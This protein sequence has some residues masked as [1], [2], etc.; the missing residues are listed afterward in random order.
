[1]KYKSSFTQPVKLSIFL[2]LLF[3]AVNCLV[4]TNSNGLHDALVFSALM[5]AFTTIFV[6]AMVKGTNI[7]VENNSVTY[8]QMSVLRTTMDIGKINKIQKDLM[9]GLYKSLSLVSEENGKSK[10]IKISTVT[11]K[12]ET[13]KLFVA[14]LT[15]QN[16][17]IFVDSSVD[18]LLS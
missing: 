13:L 14:D 5:L 15:K 12:N 8:S 6:L 11:F 17:K 10:N 16:P 4:I 3:W 18:E 2:L 7:V 1:M 9:G